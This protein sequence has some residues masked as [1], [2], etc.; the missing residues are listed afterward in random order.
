MSVRPRAAREP[1]AVLDSAGFPQA[2]SPTGDK[3]MVWG[4]PA[5]NSSAGAGFSKVDFHH[6]RRLSVMLVPN[7][8]GSFGRQLAEV[9]EAQTRVLA[10]ERAPMTVTSQTVFLSNAVDLAECQQTLRAHYGAK[11]PATNFVLQPPCCG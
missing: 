5:E 6:S 11:F 2:Q 9:L 10:A 7:G 3:R 4:Q 8:R 1:E